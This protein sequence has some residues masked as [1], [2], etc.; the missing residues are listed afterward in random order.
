MKKRII[1]GVVAGV[2]F[3]II[4]TTLVDIV[5]LTHVFRHE[6][7]DEMDSRCWRPPPHRHQRRRRWLTARLAPDH[8]MKHVLIPRMGTVRRARGRRHLEPWGS[9]PLVRHHFRRAG[10]PCGRQALRCRRAALATAVGPRESF[11]RG[12]GDGRAAASTS[13]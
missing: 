9:A 8:P 13:R 7:A 4:V 11:L 6:P 5:Y 10:D 1:W 2:L 3:I 12:A